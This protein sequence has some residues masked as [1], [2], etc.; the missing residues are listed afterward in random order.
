M[1]M[2]CTRQRMTAALVLAGLLTSPVRPADPAK[3]APAKEVPFA[4]TLQAVYLAP[5]ESRR[6]QMTSKNNL[7]SIIND[8]DGVLNVQQAGKDRTT[9][10]L[11]ARKPGFTR[12][13]LTDTDGKQEGFL[14]FVAVPAPGG[15][16]AGNVIPRGPEGAFLTALVASEDIP[17]GT[18]L[19][20]PQDYFKRVHYVK[21]GHEPKDVIQDFESL[22]GRKLKRALAEDQPIKVRDLAD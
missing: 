21:E 18:V 7:R 11:T 4:V 14:V 10:L 3:K 1:A 9:I 15:K 2:I 12:I 20:R 8:N 16:V 17:A 19:R 5:K 13:T 22:K 6:L